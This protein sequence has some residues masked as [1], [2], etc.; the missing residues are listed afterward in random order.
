[1]LTQLCGITIV[2]NVLALFQG[3]EVPKMRLKAVDHFAFVS[4]LEQGKHGAIGVGREEV[5]GGRG[6]DLPFCRRSR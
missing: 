1:M 2:T 3:T 5:G 6:A 4:S